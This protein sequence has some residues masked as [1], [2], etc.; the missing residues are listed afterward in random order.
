MMMKKTTTLKAVACLMLLAFIPLAN[1]QSQTCNGTIV[2]QDEFDGTT[3]DLNK[4]AYQTGNGCPNLCGWGNNELEYYTDNTNNVRIENGVLVIEA[5]KENVGGS[6]FTSGKLVSL[7]KF[8]RTYGRFEASIRMPKGYGTWPAFWMLNVNNQWPT[9]GEIDI[10]EYRGDRTAETHGTLHYGDS[11]PDNLWDGTT[12]NAGVDLSQ[13]F[14]E[15]AVEWD[16]NSITWFFDGVQ[17]KHVTRDPY[18]LSPPSNNPEMWPWDED[19]YMI[20]NLAIGGWFAG[21]PSADQVQLTKPTLEFDYVRVYDLNNTNDSQSAYN[22]S[23]LSIPGRIEAEEYDESCGAAYNDTDP[24]NQGGAFRSDGVDI[25]VCDEGGYNLG[26]VSQGEWVEYTVDVVTSGSYKID[27]RIASLD[28]GGTYHVEI[29]GQ[30]I[31][32]PIDVQAT[33]GWQTWQTAEKLD[34]PMSS[35]EH[36]MRI[37]FDQGEFNANYFD[38]SV[39]TAS[40]DVL[41]ATK[42]HIR[43]ANRTIRINN[44][45]AFTVASTAG[46]VIVQSDRPVKE[47]TISY[48]KLESGIYIVH[49][50]TAK[51]EFREK[52]LVD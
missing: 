26:Y 18:T 41:A 9:T 34:V 27:A 1:I 17:F 8:A 24:G 25:E 21:N 16:A 30:D 40:N 11:Y 47:H 43:V 44:V 33:G 13:E 10:M 31:S 50:L 23:P 39:I 5:R 37:V 4:W 3:L 7:G 28:V 42:H 6:S 19:F 20:L 22:G 2:W 29:D 38:F 32:G 52:I 14:H 12:Y 36:I 46:K 51:G 49:V 45:E 35:G 48:D 15:Y